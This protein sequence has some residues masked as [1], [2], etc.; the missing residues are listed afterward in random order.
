[1]PRGRT[2]S[3]RLHLTPAERRTLLAWQRAT[4]LPA[5]LA[6]RGRLLLLLA[7]GMTI[8]SHAE[9]VCARSQHLLARPRSC[10]EPSARLAAPLP[11]EGQQ[12]DSR[13]G[14]S[15]Q[16]GLRPRA[17]PSRVSVGRA[18]PG[19]GSRAG[20]APRGARGAGPPA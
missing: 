12:A 19:R 20:I 16:D 6:R 15:V 7:D 3:L 10:G 18:C 9:E 11:E 1:M 17:R 5:E 14:N 2:T 8:R 4:T 13:R